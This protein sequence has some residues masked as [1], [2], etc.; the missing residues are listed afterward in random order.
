MS[1]TAFVL[2]S[3]GVLLVLSVGLYLAITVFTVPKDA[4][5]APQTTFPTENPAGSG[6]EPGPSEPALTPGKD[7]LDGAEPDPANPGTYFIAGSFGYCAGSEPCEPI[8]TDEFNIKYDKAQD[9]FTIGI[10]QEPIGEVRVRAEEFL[11]A[12][13]GIGKEGMCRLK[14]Y[15][16]TSYWVNEAYSGQNL[17]FSFCPHAV[18]LPE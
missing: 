9:F 17:G 5:P 11:M 3:L 12:K 14:Y 16:G 8:E 15:I 13:L 18:P 4:E 1:R 7:F 6:G 10:A 2:L